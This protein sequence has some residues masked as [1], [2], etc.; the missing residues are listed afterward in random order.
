MNLPD[1][2]I[3]F[4]RYFHEKKKFDFEYEIY[5]EYVLFCLYS[6]TFQYRI[7]TNQT[8]TL[9]AGEIIV[10]PPNMAF[11]RQML[12]PS[13][14][15]MIKLKPEITLDLSIYP[16]VPEEKSRFMQNLEHLAVCNFIFDYSGNKWWIHYCRD[17]WY[18]LIS[19]TIHSHQQKDP[20]AFIQ[21]IHDY[22]LQN[23][24]QDLSMND[25]A[26]NYGFSIVHF[27]NTFCKY[28]HCTPKQYLL[29]VR[30]QRALQLL[31][32]TP[33]SIQLIAKECGFH[34]EFYFSRLFHQRF[35]MTPTEYRKV[36][37]L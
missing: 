4:C 25:I 8:Q 31:E 37:S 18:Q 24:K 17:I 1:C 34:D 6:G 15:V 29:T 30:M 12:L 3:T 10:C 20:P 36:I 28:Y 27:I 16:V 33:E 19:A 5:E 9:R 23:Y 22:I 11:H 2:E 35:G 13:T 14:F 26:R 7:G 21:D 32:D